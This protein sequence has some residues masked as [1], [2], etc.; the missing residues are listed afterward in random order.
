MRLERVALRGTVEAARPRFSCR[1]TRWNGR[2]VPTKKRLR[3][4]AIKW[5]GFRRNHPEK[6]ATAKTPGPLP[7]Q[8]GEPTRRK[9]SPATAN[10]LA[11]L[12][13]FFYYASQHDRNLPP[14]AGA[15]CERAPCRQSTAH[16]NTHSRAG[17]PRLL[18]YRYKCNLFE[19]LYVSQSALYAPAGGSL[20]KKHLQIRFPLRRCRLNAYG[21]SN[22]SNTLC[23]RPYADVCLGS[24][25]GIARLKQPNK[26][27]YH[28]VSHRKM[29]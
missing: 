17:R 27:S 24:R 13:L 22:G 10:G 19:L 25:Q 8:R 18:L 5:Q 7:P 29:P 6:E 26:N 2:A 16:K 3:E 11:P 21:A 12:S 20:N 15:A 1:R 28:L 14:T 4:T 23:L 9:G